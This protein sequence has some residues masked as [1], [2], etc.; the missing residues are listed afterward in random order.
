MAGIRSASSLLL[1]NASLRLQLAEAQDTLSAIRNGEVDALVVEGSSGPRVYTLQGVE[2]ET[3]R[4]R[5]KMLEQVSDA[6][7]ALDDAGR[8]VYLNAAAERLYNFSASAILGHKQAALYET[9]WLLPADEPAAAG[10]LRETGAWRG[11]LIHVRRDGREMYV[12]LG[13]TI[14]RETADR[15][16]GQLLVVRDVTERRRR[17]DQIL[18]SEIRYR[19]LFETAHDGVLLLDPRTRKIIDANPFMTRIL[20]YPHD[21]LI[22]KELFQIGLL[23]DEAASQAMFRKLKKNKQVR[24]DNLPL[25]TQTGRLQDVEVVANLYEENGRLIIQCNIR[26]IT[27]RR[28]SE[29]H[30]NLLMA[31]INHRAKNLLAVVQAVAHQTAYHGDPATFVTRLSDRIGSLAAGQDL[32]VRNQ[33]QGVDVRD[34]VESQL[35]HFKDLIG[36]RVFL[37]HKPAQLSAP[38]AQGIGMA[39]HELATNSA[40]YGALSN[41]YGYVTIDWTP[42]TGTEPEFSISWKEAGGPAV[43]M[44]ARKG[45]GQVVIGRMAAAAVQGVADIA[46]HPAGVTWTLTAPAGNALMPADGFGR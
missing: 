3:S 23:A 1:E 22:G 41:G 25:V 40:K 36:S 33:W 26:D 28:R 35:A 16:A 31:E 15:P 18:V 34:L 11:E 7:I 10:V 13:V 30:V 38:A 9:R 27:E 5:G 12:D 4:F 39:L 45:F 44:P 6:V 43:A 37:G 29:E 46:F 32:L 21:K 42:G 19:R 24:Y 2:A 8:I 14:L 20:D 17:D